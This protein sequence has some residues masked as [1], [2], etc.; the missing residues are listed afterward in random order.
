MA[1]PSVGFPG[2]ATLEWVAGAAGGGKVVGGRRMTGGLTSSIHRL[3]VADRS[4]MRRHVVLRRWIGQDLDSG[5]GNVELEGRVLDHLSRSGFPAPALLGISDGSETDG[6]AALLMTRVPGRVFL[7]PRDPANWLAQIAALLPR[8]HA[9]DPP[10][11]VPVYEPK[12]RAEARP[13]PEWVSR[14]DVWNAAQSVLME[15]PPESPRSFVHADFQHFNMLWQREKLTGI[16]DWTWPGLAPPDSDVGHCRLNLAVLHSADW[17]EQ[18]RLAYEA[19]AGRKV[20]PWF[21][22][23]GLMGFSTDWQGFIP[24]QVGGRAPLD[25]DGMPRRVE[26]LIASVLKRL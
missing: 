19:E 14:P 23:R 2:A 21:D 18:F 5:R 13:T 16:V 4:G 6:V 12:A 22:L 26:E 25:V 17:A 10:E 9:L 24:I 20:D 1:N 7:T 15:A 8:V 3:T 11:G